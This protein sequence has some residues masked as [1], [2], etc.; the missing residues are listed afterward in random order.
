[1]FEVIV[2]LSAVVEAGQKTVFTARITITGT[3]GKREYSLLPLAIP[4]KTVSE[5]SSVAALSPWA[6]FV[7]LSRKQPLTQ[8]GIISLNFPVLGSFSISSTISTS[9]PT[10]SFSPF[11]RRMEL[12]L[13]RIFERTTSLSPWIFALTRSLFFLAYGILASSLYLSEL[14]VTRSLRKACHSCG[15]WTRI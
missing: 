2:P 13:L 15:Q 9:R 12:I 5:K 8:Y 6:Y 7:V 11:S 4:T 14:R 10:A 3:W 1:M